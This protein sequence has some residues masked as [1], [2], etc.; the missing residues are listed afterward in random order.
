MANV[1]SLVAFFHLLGGRRHYFTP[2]ES[3]VRYRCHNNVLADDRVKQLSF[4]M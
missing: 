1:N 2:K 4:Q 3:K